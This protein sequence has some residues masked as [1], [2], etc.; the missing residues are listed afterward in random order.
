MR[1]LAIYPMGPENIDICTYLIR[2]DGKDFYRFSK[3]GRKWDWE[4]DD[5]A[6]E[7]FTGDLPYDTLT[8]EQA[9]YVMERIKSGEAAKKQYEVLTRPLKK[10]RK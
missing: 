3:N 4:K 9:K 2:D 5:D 10:A 6:W 8:E 1:Y 7:I